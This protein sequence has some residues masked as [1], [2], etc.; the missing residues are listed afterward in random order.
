MQ[1]TMFTD[2]AFR[3][4]MYLGEKKAQATISEI[5]KTFDISQNHLIKVAHR[6][7]KQ[8]FIHTIKGRGGGIQLALP[9]DQI[10]LSEVVRRNEPHMNLLECLDL[11]TNTCPVNGLCRL[12]HIIIE[13]RKG[14]LDVLERYTLFDLLGAHHSELP[15]LIQK[16]LE[17]STEHASNE[18]NEILLKKE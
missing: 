14:F 8:G 10:R 17:G 16:T 18:F 5:A 2:Y 6:L 12:K 1:L 4:L 9:P 15:K 13:S 3:I 7:G 11:E